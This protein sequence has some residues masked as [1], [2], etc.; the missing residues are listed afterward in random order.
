MFQP[1]KILIVE[2]IDLKY[3]VMEFDPTKEKTKALMEFFEN[4]NREVNGIDIK[5]LKKTVSHI[6]IDTE[7]D[8]ILKFINGVEISNRQVAND[9]E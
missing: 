7:G 6:V 8:V 9:G 4:Y 2:T 5:L 1:I 3:Q